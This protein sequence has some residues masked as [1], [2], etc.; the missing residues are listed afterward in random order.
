M[1]VEP[2]VAYTSRSISRH[3]VDQAER[4]AAPA[5]IKAIFGTGRV[6]DEWLEQVK[7]TAGLPGEVWIEAEIV[8]PRSG[9]WRTCDIR[10]RPQQVLSVLRLCKD[11]AAEQRSRPLAPA[12][13][14]SSQK[15]I[16]S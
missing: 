1:I 15:A 11:A 5:E 2:R 9:R 4:D 7:A 13:D 6:P 10:I 3:E 12:S 8:D 14:S 16:P